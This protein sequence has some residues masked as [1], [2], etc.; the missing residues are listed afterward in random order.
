MK[1]LTEISDYLAR[2]GYGHCI[3]FGAVYVGDNRSGQIV[4][5]ET[6]RSAVHF[7]LYA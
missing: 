7:V 4:R 2:H 3:E 1:N 6:L 5:I